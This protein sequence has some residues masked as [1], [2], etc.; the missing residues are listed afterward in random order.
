MINVSM[1]KH[2]RKWMVFF[3]TGLQKCAEE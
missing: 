2:Q 3:F 1:G